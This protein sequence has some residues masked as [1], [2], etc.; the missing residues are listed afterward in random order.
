MEH[1]SIISS[2][3][4]KE[5]F[6]HRAALYLSRMLKEKYNA[7]A[8][9]LDLLDYNFP[10]FEER[11]KYLDSPSPDTID[12]AERVRKA[13]GLIMVVP[14]YNG[15]YPASIKNVIDLLTDEWRKKPVAFAVVSNG[16]FGGSQVVFSLQFTLWKIMA[17]TVSPA[18]RIS[19]IETSI[20]DN[21]IPADRVL[22][23][24]MAS[25]TIRE[26][27]WHIEA[28]RRMAQ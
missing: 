15:G 1:I 28:K 13:D 25:S 23:D 16:R 10:L 8:E 18:L 7:E 24:K 3:I 5:R 12:F 22:M 14:E 19:D 17:L 2:S 9:I 6:S 21:G 27:L 20:D 4:R 11:L 26:L